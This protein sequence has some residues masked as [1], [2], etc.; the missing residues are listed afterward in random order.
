MQIDLHADDVSLFASDGVIAKLTKSLSGSHSHAKSVLRL[1]YQFKGAGHALIRIPLGLAL[2]ANYVFRFSVRGNSPANTLEFKCVDPSGENVWW[3]NR[4]NFA[5]SK[6]W[7]RLSNKRRHFTYAWGP[8]NMPLTEVGFIELTVSA[9]TGGKGTLYFS[10][11]AFAQLAVASDRATS[12]VVKTS[13]NKAHA[14]SIRT[15]AAEHDE[16][17]IW[18]SST[19]ERQYVH[20]QFGALRE[21]DGLVVD[22]GDDYAVDYEVQLP[23]GKNHWRT[24]DTISGGRR[25]RQYHALPESEAEA[26]RLVFKQSRRGC[27]YAVKSIAVQPIGFAASTTQFFANLAKDQAPGFSPRYF[28]NQQS[29]WTVVGVSGGREKAIINEEGMIEP[30]LQTPSLEPFIFTDGKLLTWADGEHSQSLVDNHKPMPV[31]RRSHIEQKLDLTIETFSQGPLQAPDQATLYTRYRIKNN[32]ES[33]RNGSF[34]LALRHY[35]VNPPWQFLN[36]PGGFA[37]IFSLEAHDSCMAVT[38]NGQWQILPQSKPDGF[39]LTRLSQGEIVEHLARG[40]LPAFEGPGGARSAIDAITISDQRGYCSGA[41]QYRFDLAAG[42]EVSFALALPYSSASKVKPFAW[43][44]GEAIMAWNKTLKAIDIDLPAYPELVNTIKSQLGYILVNRDGKALQ[45]GSRCYRRT[46]IRDGSLTSEALLQLGQAAEVRAFIDWFAPY[47]Y[48]DGKVPCCV[49]KRGADPTPEHDSHGEFIYLVVEYFRYSK[50]KEHL[51]R[52]FPAVLQAVRYI[53][54]LRRQLLTEQY[55]QPQNAHLYGLLPESISHEGY[56]AKPA[57]S[58][59]D[60]IFALKGLEDALFAAQVLADQQSATYIGD[61]YR[62]FRADLVASMKTAMAKWQIAYIPGAA[63]RGDFDPTSITIALDPADMSN[64][65]LPELKSTFAA[66][67]QFFEKR[68]ADQIK[69]EN[70]TP[71]EW[72]SVGTMVKLGEIDKAHQAMDFFMRDRRPKGWNHWAEVVF[73]DPHTPRFIGDAPHGW[74]GSDFLRAVRTLFVYEKEDALVVGAGLRQ[75]WLKAGLSANNLA[76]EYGHFSLVVSHADGLLTYELSG[77]IQPNVA[78]H[79]MVPDK[80]EKTDGTNE[81]D[82]RRC[83]V[84]DHLPATI[85]VSL[86]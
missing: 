64:E 32:G 8:V 34:F 60:D 51:R 72:R 49:D 3:V 27:G 36:S 44:R 33:R 21:F 47:Q 68:R 43:A 85:T 66:Y 23:Q 25:H 45:P 62:A 58:Y 7:Q 81:T 41:L 18:R 42:Q 55:R 67:W 52:L 20:L 26:V 9:T 70:Y 37:P 48:A 11:L 86:K 2:P 22:F 75:D 56:S 71:Y 15:A 77:D 61:I 5:F 79:L 76:T 74:V 10:D 17:Q 40:H 31:V 57:H 59:W 65:L 1:D 14:A 29:F 38:V 78:V 19:S 24:V 53:D 46:W 82:A 35:Q 4:P 69:W 30:A 28:Q 84:V 80:E 12:I 54:G 39:G 50:D 63:D 16:D 6:N 83:V 73:K 13:S